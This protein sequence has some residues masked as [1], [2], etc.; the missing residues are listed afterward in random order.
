MSLILNNTSSLKAMIGISTFAFLVGCSQKQH[1]FC[2]DDTE[3]CSLPTP[4]TLSQSAPISKD[5]NKQETPVARAEFK[6]SAVRQS[7]ETIRLSKTSTQTSVKVIEHI[8]LPAPKGARYSNLALTDGK[9]SRIN[10]N[11]TYTIQLGAYKL[12]SSRQTAISRLENSE[13]LNLYSMTNGYLGLSYGRYQ[14][15]SE[16]LNKAAQLRERG[17]QDLYITKAR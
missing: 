16:A 2:I 11:G 12:E 13:S 3:N 8:R 10:T 6:P 17:F 14:T 1:T 5:Y 15:Q 4:P 9:N 7:Q